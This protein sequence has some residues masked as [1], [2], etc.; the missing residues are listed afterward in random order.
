VKNILF[1]FAFI[2]LSVALFSQDNKR[3]QFDDYDENRVYFIAAG[4]ELVAPGAGFWV[5]ML[6]YKKL[7][8]MAP[9]SIELLINNQINEAAIK[10][11]N[12]N[13]VI[14][15]EKFWSTVWMVAGCV[16]GVALIGTVTFIAIHYGL[17]HKALDLSFSF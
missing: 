10:I 1:V 2:A 13:K 8:P 14:K 3:Y 6:M 7:L 15:T 9:A 4:L 12:L 11:A 5:P 16:L 17:D